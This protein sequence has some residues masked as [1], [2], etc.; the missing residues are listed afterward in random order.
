[1]TVAT[2]PPAPRDA[3]LEAPIRFDGTLI[4]TVLARVGVDCVRCLVD[5][6]AEVVPGYSEGAEAMP[7]RVGCAYA[8]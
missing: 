7:H 5:A 2:G 4:G 6:V 1:M 8:G 3:L